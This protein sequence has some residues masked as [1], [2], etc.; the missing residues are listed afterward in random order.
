M[1]TTVFSCGGFCCWW[2][3]AAAQDF[4]VRC[5]S[6]LVAVCSPGTMSLSQYIER[7][8]SARNPSER[9][10]TASGSASAS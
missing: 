5:F 10:N 8:F 1:L 3:E 2:R 9:R 7:I 6:M 4:F